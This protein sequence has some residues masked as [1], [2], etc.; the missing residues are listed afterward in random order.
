MPRTRPSCSLERDAM[1]GSTVG[2][3]DINS[4]AGM[5]EPEIGQLLEAGYRR[6]VRAWAMYDWA[7][8]AYITVT[9]TTFFP[10]FFVAIAAPAFL[11]TGSGGGADP[12]T[13]ARDTA[14]NVYALTVSLALM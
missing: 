5:Q 6:R 13:L 7:N 10:P 14:S 11:G 2:G 12:L 3:A 4:R 1:L 8:S 9:S